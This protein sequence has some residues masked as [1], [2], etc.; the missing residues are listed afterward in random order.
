[1]GMDDEH[2]K[3]SKVFYPLLCI[4]VAHVTNMSQH[5]PC[6]ATRD[7]GDMS[8][9]VTTCREISRHVTM[10][11]Q[12][13]LPDTDMSRRHLMTCQEDATQVASDDMSCRQHVQHSCASSAL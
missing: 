10:S 8:P 11:P 13:C 7:I 1:M 2:K 6:D 5:D 3:C 12:K 4:Y 9:N